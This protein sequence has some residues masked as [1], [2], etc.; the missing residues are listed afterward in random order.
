MCHHNLAS[1]RRGHTWV[2]RGR[3]AHTQVTRATAQSVVEDNGGAGVLGGGK[4][5]VNRAALGDEEGNTAA[6]GVTS[7]VDNALSVGAAGRGVAGAARVLEVPVVPAGPDR[8]AVRLPVR[9]DKL[10]TPS[11][12]TEGQENQ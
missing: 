4:T 11:D 12:W 10:L 7:V 1:T 9:R 5:A 2:T 3:G 8:R 6:D